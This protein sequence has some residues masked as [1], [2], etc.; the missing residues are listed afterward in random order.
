[1]RKV[2]RKDAP[3]QRNGKSTEHWSDRYKVLISI[4]AWTILIG[5]FVFL[6][7]MGPSIR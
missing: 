4:V 5:S 1:M 6:T 7:W 3:K 2:V